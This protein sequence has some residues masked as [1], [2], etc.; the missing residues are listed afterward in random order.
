MTKRPWRDTAWIVATT[1]GLAIGGFVF[2]FPG[3]FGEASWQVAALVVGAIMGGITGV[4]VALLQWAA[5]RLPRDAGRR[6]V[7]WMTLAIGATH[8]LNDGAPAS[9]GIIPLSIACGVGVSLTY[10]WTVRDIDVVRL[11]AIGGGWAMALL[12]AD[13]VDTA[14]ALPFDETP[15][16]W[17]TQHAISGVV[18]GVAWGLTT[19]LAD[20]PGR[21]LARGA[22]A[23]EGP[24]T[25]SPAPVR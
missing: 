21:I 20:V 6:L 5:Q 12:A 10:A 25:K 23:R 14:L 8:A 4:G 18:V 19:V 9:L 17:A 7:V 11:A 2:H 3:S 13:G 16:G 15:V 1:M 22:A 24:V